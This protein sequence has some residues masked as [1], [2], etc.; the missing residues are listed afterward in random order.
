[1]PI[2]KRWTARR[3]RRATGEAQRHPLVRNSAASQLTQ[4]G[5]CSDKTAFW[6]NGA[7]SW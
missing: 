3:K 7:L 5:T 6:G 2:Y 4:E 1:V